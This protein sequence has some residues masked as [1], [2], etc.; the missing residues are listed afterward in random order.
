M[1]DFSTLCGRHENLAVQIPY[2]RSDGPLNLLV[3]S[4]GI[5]FLADG[6]GQ[7]SK[8]GVPGRHQ[9]R[10]V[11]LAMVPATSDIRAVEFKPSLAGPSRG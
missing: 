6:E 1:P 9:W 2:R 8:H 4:T 7:A 5:T 10:N 3:D 11:H